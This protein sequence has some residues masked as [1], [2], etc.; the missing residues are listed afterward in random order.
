MYP[1]HNFSI[2][3]IRY[4][5]QLLSNTREPINGILEEINITNNNSKLLTTLT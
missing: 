4:I 5:L 2:T 1:G 3:F